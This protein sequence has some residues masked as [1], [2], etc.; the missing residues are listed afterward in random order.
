VS[1]GLPDITEPPVDIFLLLTKFPQTIFNFSALLL[2]A[3]FV[4]FLILAEN[5]AHAEFERVAFLKSA[6]KQIDAEGT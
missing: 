5:T 1:F 4:P 6:A 2:G 3:I